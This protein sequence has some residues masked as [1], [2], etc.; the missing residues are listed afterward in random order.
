[1]H[2]WQFVSFGPHL[3]APSIRDPTFIGWDFGPSVNKNNKDIGRSV[4]SIKQ[5]DVQYCA[6]DLIV[7]WSDDSL[8]WYYA[9][10]INASLMLNCPRNATL[11]PTSGVTISPPAVTNPTP[12]PIPDHPILTFTRDSP[13]SYGGKVLAI[14][15]LES[16][17]NVV[18]EGRSKAEA[19]AKGG[20]AA[21]CDYEA[22]VDSSNL[23]EAGSL[24]DVYVAVSAASTAAYTLDYWWMAKT[25]MSMHVKMTEIVA[26]TMRAA[27][28]N[29]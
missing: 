18:G 22:V 17:R 26:G 1:M 21:W 11:N 14:M 20:G 7:Q 9:W 8:C 29:T 24:G 3:A 13:L 4:G 27:G 25:V 10:Q 16:G 5:F 15:S 2:Y 28:G 19:F 6:N 23:P 12:A